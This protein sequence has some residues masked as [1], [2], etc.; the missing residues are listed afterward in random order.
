M[1]GF[2]HLKIDNLYSGVYVNTNETIIESKEKK[3]DE[4]KSNSTQPRRSSCVC[5]PIHH[6][7]M[8]PWD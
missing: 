2:L 6:E 5:A 8:I 1:E 3:L 7:N 4:M